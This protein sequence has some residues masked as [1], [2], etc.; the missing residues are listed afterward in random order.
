VYSLIEAPIDTFQSITW[1]APSNTNRRAS[2]PSRKTEP[3]TA[4]L[5]QGETSSRTN[6]AVPDAEIAVP[7]AEIA[8]PD[9]EI[10][11]PDT[12]KLDPDRE[13]PSRTAPASSR[14]A[15]SSSRTPVQQQRQAKPHAS[16]EAL[17]RRPV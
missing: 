17:E 2:Y 3:C 4:N 16:E 1:R 12:G 13:C 9:T 7:D 6:T 5:L 11:V 15:P 8:V 14:T 10:A